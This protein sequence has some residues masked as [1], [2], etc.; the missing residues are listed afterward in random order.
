MRERQ[1]QAAGERL[2]QQ[3][4][5]LLVGRGIGEEGVFLARIREL[6]QA[7]GRGVGRL[8]RDYTKNHFLARELLQQLDLPTI[9]PRSVDTRLLVWRGEVQA[10][11]DRLAE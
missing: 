7:F 6:A 3:V 1:V 4:G 5:A 8:T 9:W 11:L 2:E 10:R